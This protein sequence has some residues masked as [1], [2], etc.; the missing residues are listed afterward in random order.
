MVRLR[1]A[2]GVTAFVLAIAS[3]GGALAQKKTLTVGM[4]SADAGKLDPHLTATTPD[5]GVLNWMFNGL[6]RIRPGQVS[7]EFIEPDIAES[8]TSNPPGTEWTFKLR[9]GVQC[10]HDYGE[11][12]AE[13]AAYSLQRAATKATSAFSSDFASVEKIEPVDKL[14][15]K[16]TLKNPV[17]GFLGYLVNYHGGNMVCK[18]AAEEMKDNFSKLP[19]GT[20]PFEFAEYQPQQFVRLVANKKYFRGV[21]Q[22]QE[23]IYRYVPSNASRDLAFQSGELDMIYGTQE[24]TWV[25]RISKLPGVRVAT[26]ELA[27]MSA[28][29]LNTQSKPLDDIRVRQ[30][31]AHAIDRQSIVAFKGPSTSRLAVSVVPSGYLG[32]DEHA[33]L[34]DFDLTKSKQLLTEAGHPDGV[35]VKAIHTTLPSMQQVIEV[36]QAQ[37]KK[38]NINLDVEL[39]EHATFH[40]KIREDLSPIVHYQAARFPVADVYLTQF[41]H[42]RSQVGTPTAVTNFTHCN[43]A[44]AE[45]DAARI[46]PDAAKQKALWKTAQEKLIRHVC[47]IPIYEQLQVWAWKDSLDLGYDL[48]GSLNL[49][50][51]IIETTHF[52]K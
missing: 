48:K 46:E 32:T 35:T 17:P 45:I 12:T 25:E 51:P 9:P 47:G 27:E 31:I 19:I 15:L 3:S 16:I 30:A 2:V 7:P 4:A 33:P 5:K 44:D 13:D 21:P 14:T 18:K 6:V 43:L 20:G 36:V 24:Q 37:L 11:F 1:G 50:P 23:I 28:L 42:S 22:L 10:H 41:Y 8:W 39:V 29:Y 52:T 49:S 26:L 34:Y 40:Q 38:A